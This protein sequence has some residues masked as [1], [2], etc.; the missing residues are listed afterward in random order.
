MSDASKTKIEGKDFRM[1]VLC[2]EED[3]RRAIN[4]EEIHYVPHEIGPFSIVVPEKFIPLLKKSGVKIIQVL[5]SI[6]ENRLTPEQYKDI[7]EGKAFVWTF[8]EG[9]FFTDKELNDQLMHN[10]YHKKGDAYEKK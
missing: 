9:S 2:S 1:V 8:N 4:I 7:E 3:F 6:D 5:K 10:D